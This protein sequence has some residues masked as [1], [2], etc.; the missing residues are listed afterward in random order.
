MVLAQVVVEGEAFLNA[1]PGDLLAVVA[2]SVVLPLAVTV[3][4]KLSAPAY[5]KN[6]VH[7]V[8]A[9]V[10]GVGAEGQGVV[11]NGEDWHWQ[12]ALF[13]AVVTWVMSTFAYNKVWKDSAVN[14]KLTLATAEIGVGA[15]PPEW[16]ATDSALSV[17]LVG[18]VSTPT[19]PPVPLDPSAMTR[20]P[21]A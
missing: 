1:P 7:A 8:L 10:A 17:D 9:V 21:E 18:G 13:V 3:L 12:K 4:T 19:Q 20:P 6:W 5:V 2:M 11:F 14:N 16:P 15:K